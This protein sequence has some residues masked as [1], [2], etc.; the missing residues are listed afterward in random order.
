M[1]QAVKK[2]RGG[3][4]EAHFLGGRP[5]AVKVTVYTADGVGGRRSSTM[6]ATLDSVA[7]GVDDGRGPRRAGR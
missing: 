4:I 1:I 5:S 6:D 7:Y 3:L 2:G